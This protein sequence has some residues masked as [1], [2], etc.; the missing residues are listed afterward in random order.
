MFVLRGFAQLPEEEFLGRWFRGIL[1][2]GSPDSPKLKIE[3]AS[4]ATKVSKDEYLYEI[5]ITNSGDLDV[6]VQSRILDKLL[7]GRFCFPHIVSVKS[8]ETKLFTLKTDLS[9]AISYGKTQ[10]FVWEKTKV[11]QRE[12]NDMLNVELNGQ[13]TYPN[14]KIIVPIG[15]S[16]T[17]GVVPEIFS[18][19]I[20]E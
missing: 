19:C 4:R 11:S 16:G 1:T 10:V 13:Y 5:K 8:E 2:I 15:G 3:V 17:S 20:G 7:T 9:P 18:K 6:L 12:N 14:G